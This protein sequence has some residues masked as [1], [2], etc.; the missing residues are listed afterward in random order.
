M[1]DGEAGESGN[2]IDNAMREVW[3][4][5]D[6]EDSVRVYEPVHGRDRDPVRRRGT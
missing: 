5:A 4:R 3:C 6:E 1:P 2:V